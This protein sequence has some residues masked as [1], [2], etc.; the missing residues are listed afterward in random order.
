MALCTFSSK[1][2]MDGYTVIDNTFLNEF[3]PSA[4]GDNVK[5]YLY[6]LTLCS[7]PNVEDNTL[8]TMC[9]VLSLTEEQVLSAFSYWQEMGL[10]QLV[11]S[12]PLEIKFLPIRAHSGSAKIR[13]TGKYADFNIQ[14]QAF[15]DRMITPNEFN[16][17]YSIMEIEHI[18]PEAF[19]LIANY[20]TKIKSRSI[21]YPYILAV[22]RDFARDGLKTLEAVEQKFVEQ[23]KNSKEI[24]Q[25]LDALG[26]KRE[27]DID[28]R[29]LYIKWTNKF[30]FTHGVVIQIA[31]TLKKKG[32]FIKLD[33]LL[34]KYYEQRL[35]SL[36]E[37][38]SYSDARELMFET[39]RNISKTLGLYYQNIEPVVDTYVSD[40]TN[41]GFA[42]ETLEWISNYCFKQSIRTL[43]GMN[44][45][46][47]KFYKL[48]VISFDSIKQYISSILQADEQIKELLD[49][50]GLLRSVNSYDRDFY[51]TWTTNWNFTHEQILLAAQNAKDKLNQMTYLNRLLADLHENGKHTSSEIEKHLKKSP[52]SENKTGKK[53]KFN[54]DQREFTSS[55][56][57]AVI[58]SLDDVEF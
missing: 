26:L 39:A 27:A 29:N 11:S 21:G 44:T 6:G 43:D 24:K 42:P 10:V 13:N 52:V 15:F 30:G 8:D 34:S 3:L 46:V 22:A 16:E 55:E 4:T 2:V 23:E 17:Y 32:G 51:K 25:L 47:Q 41:K 49:L 20:C 18:E 9:K 14:L 54:H 31:K 58:D 40:W 48:G 33:S 53:P 56:F 5:V 36:E 45:I 35:F 57:S 50:F 37:I 1:L 12:N 38:T 7:N 19:L 28:E